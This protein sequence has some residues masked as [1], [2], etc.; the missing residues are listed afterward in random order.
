MSTN[1]KMEQAGIAERF[2][3]VASILKG[4]KG[5]TGEYGEHISGARSVRFSSIHVLSPEVCC[6]V[7]AANISS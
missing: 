2:D 6:C 1:L 7:A 3:A 4:S 5:H